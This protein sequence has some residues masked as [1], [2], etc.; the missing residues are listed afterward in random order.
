[1][2]RS[3]EEI[4]LAIERV[5]T[6]QEYEASETQ[7]LAEQERLASQAAFERFLQVRE[8]WLE[9][10][11]AKGYP[12]AVVLYWGTPFR[13]IRQETVNETIGWQLGTMQFRRDLGAYGSVSDPS[14]Y[15]LTIDNK[16]LVGNA[17]DPTTGATHVGYVQDYTRMVGGEALTSLV[18]MAHQHGLD[19]HP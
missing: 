14:P 8:S 17:L 7:R 13:S 6:Q 2:P 4:R 15:W 9:A 3:P 16:F 1:M 18:G 5:K 19:W 11:A 10:M 12:G